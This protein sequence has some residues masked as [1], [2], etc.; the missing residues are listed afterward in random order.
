MFHAVR[1]LLLADLMVGALVPMAATAQDAAQSAD[2]AKVSVATVFDNYVVDT[3]LAGMWGHASVVAVPTSRVLFDTGSDGAVLLDNLRSMEIA[4]R[5]V[6][7][8]VIS[9]AHGDHLG[10][11][12]GFLAE[13][14]DVVVY[15][16]ASFPSS[17]KDAIRDAGARYL[18]VDGPMEIVEGIWTTGPMDAGLPEQA[19]MVDSGEG[20]IVMTGCAHPGIVKAVTE[21]KRLFPDRPIALVMGGFHL[22]SATDAEID[23]IIGAFRRLSVRKVAPS[24]CTGDRARARFQAEYGDDYIA[25]GA[26][27]RMDFGRD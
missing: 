18:D 22:V 14:N 15:I 9:H 4:P 1:L 20:L 21:A 24:H 16:P 13:N 26:G 17:V 19:L 11:L 25:G 12:R 2:S 7:A 23:R 6:D 5:D 3:R 10:G 8:V 27:R